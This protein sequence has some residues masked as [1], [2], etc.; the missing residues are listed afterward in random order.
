[1]HQGVGQRQF[2]KGKLHLG[3]EGESESNR[4]SPNFQCL[5]RL[6]VNMSKCPPTYKQNVHISLEL[7]QLTLLPFAA[8]L[9]VYLGCSTS[10][11]S[12]P[13]SVLDNQAASPAGSLRVLWQWS[14]TTQCPV[15]FLLSLS[16]LASQPH[17]KP[18]TTISYAPDK[19]GFWTSS[20]LAL[21]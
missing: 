20:Q 19:T 16:C 10:R 5:L 6:T 8:K 12:V 1:M 13:S 4:Y 2:P 7:L 17:T 15:P 9:L 14:P 3:E 11:L 21:L 18:L